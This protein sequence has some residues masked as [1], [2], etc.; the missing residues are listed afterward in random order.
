MNGSEWGVW[1]DLGE[2]DWWDGR[3]AFEVGR[4]R[5]RHVRHVYTDVV[6]GCPYLSVVG[7]YA[8]VSL[9]SAH[10]YVAYTSYTLRKHAD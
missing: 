7:M 2:V 4:G 9:N 3:V 6:Q 5:Q 1:G 8:G 10:V